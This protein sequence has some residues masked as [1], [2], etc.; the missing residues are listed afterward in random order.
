MHK[1]GRRHPISAKTLTLEHHCI[2]NYLKILLNELCS[3]MHKKIPGTVA[4]GNAKL[5]FGN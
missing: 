3:G 5:L 4:I 2:I 1:Q